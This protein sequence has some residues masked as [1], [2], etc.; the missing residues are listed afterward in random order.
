MQCFWSLRAIITG[1]LLCMYIDATWSFTT[2]LWLIFGL[3]G[4]NKNGSKSIMDLLNRT[5][6]RFASCILRKNHEHHNTMY[7]PQRGILS[8]WMPI[9]CTPT[10]FLSPNLWPPVTLLGT[11]TDRNNDGPDLTRIFG[12]GALLHIPWI[13]NKKH[14]FCESGASST[15]GDGSH[16][17]LPLG[18]YF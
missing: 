18:N 14:N 17:C 7:V 16:C 2:E 9:T 12:P 13:C 5:A 15:Y 11:Q 8:E 4:L 3:K 1:I 6:F 10:H